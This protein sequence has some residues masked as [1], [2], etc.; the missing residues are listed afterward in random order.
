MLLLELVLQEG[1][2]RYLQLQTARSGS[3]STAPGLEEEHLHRLEA[4]T[5]HARL[6]MGNTCTL[7]HYLV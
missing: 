1:Q 3:V 5:L 4:Q 7:Q 6:P 2:Q